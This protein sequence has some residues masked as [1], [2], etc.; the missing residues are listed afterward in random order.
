MYF[1]RNWEFGSA[2]SKLRNNFGGGVWTPTNYPPGYASELYRYSPCMPLCQVQAQRYLFVINDSHMYLAALVLQI[3]TTW[4]LWVTSGQFTLR[5]ES[6]VAFKR[7]CTDTKK[8]V[9][10]I[11][12]IYGKLSPCLLSNEDRRL[13][14]CDR[15]RYLY[16]PA[17]SWRLICHSL[18]AWNEQAVGSIPNVSDNFCAAKQYKESERL[19]RSCPAMDHSTRSCVVCSLQRADR[20]RQHG[21]PVGRHTPPHCTAEYS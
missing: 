21:T 18:S 3:P 10:Y 17:V 16:R 11:M 9:Q 19:P 12:C 2:L 8:H 15:T 20:W 1:P 4:K 6:F 13:E 7:S 5:W 14:V